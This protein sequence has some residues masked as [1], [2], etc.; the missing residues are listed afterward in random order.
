MYKSNR[1]AAGQTHVLAAILRRKEVA[2]VRSDDVWCFLA[3][4]PW[5]Y[6][7]LTPKPENCVQNAS[8]A[9]Y[10]TRMFLQL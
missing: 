4:F 3:H 10:N 5:K 9:G 2:E 1:K 8:S 7:A 6:T